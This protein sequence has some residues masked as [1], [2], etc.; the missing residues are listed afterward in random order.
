MKD[1]IISS[2]NHWSIGL[3]FFKLNPNYLLITLIQKCLRTK[4]EVFLVSCKNSKQKILFFMIPKLDIWWLINH[5]ITLL[6]N[7][8]VEDLTG[9]SSLQGVYQHSWAGAGC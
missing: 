7:Q 9:H 1:K 6:F 4:L 3:V 2:L 5:F 8:E